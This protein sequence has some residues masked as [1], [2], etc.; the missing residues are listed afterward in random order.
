MRSRGV[1]ITGV[2]LTV[3][4]SLAPAADS[5][6]FESMSWSVNASG[7]FRIHSALGTERLRQRVLGNS[8]DAEIVPGSPGSF[9]ISGIFGGGDVTG[10]AR[11]KGRRFR[12]SLDQGGRLQFGGFL[13]ESAEN[14]VDSGVATLRSFR[15]SGTATVSRDISRVTF[16]LRASGHGS[17]RYRGRNVPG[18]FDATYR[19][20]TDRE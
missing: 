12:L 15:A 18:T 16:R 19:V 11:G 17:G 5:A 2:A 14:L 4:P 20:F 1:W 13:E 3:L 6:A 10:V 8:Q 7:T 9:R